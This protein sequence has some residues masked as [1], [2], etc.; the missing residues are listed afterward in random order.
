MLTNTAE[1]DAA[2]HKAICNAAGNRI[3]QRM[4]EALQEALK[5]SMEV[6]A[7]LAPPERA[8]EFHQQV[9]LA[10]HLRQPAQ[11]RQKMIDHLNDAQGVFLS[12]FLDGTLSKQAESNAGD[13]LEFPVEVVQ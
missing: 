13:S 1:A 11:A 9:Y 2:F 4:F 3:G 7:Q 12:A 10:I 8:L 6:T 5:Q